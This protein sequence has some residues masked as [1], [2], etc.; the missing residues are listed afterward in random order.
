MTV[1]SPPS[2][3]GDADIGTVRIVL[4]LSGIDT[5]TSAIHPEGPTANASVHVVKQPKD[6]FVR[7]TSIA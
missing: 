6:L 5:L 7:Q 4:H 2:F 3:S 1:F